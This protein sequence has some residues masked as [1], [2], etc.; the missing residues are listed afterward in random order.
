[1]VQVR[2]FGADPS[3]VGMDLYVPRSVRPHPAILLALA[4]CE[5]SGSDF[6][7]FTEFARLAD[8]YGFIVIYPSSAW[9]DG[10]WDVSSAAALRHDGGS[11]PVAFMSMITYVE[12]T[13]H[14]DPRRVYVTG[15]SS[16]AMM[17]A[18][19]LG[20]YP[21]VFKAGA[22]FMGVPFGCFAGPGPDV[23]DNACTSG[24][25]RMSTQR[26]GD[27]VRAADPGYHGPRPRVQIWHGTAD[28]TV[29]YADFGAEIRQWTN[30][31]GVS[32]TPVAT[33]HPR[34]GWT[35][36]EYGA[37]KNDI[38]IEAYSILGADHVLP[39]PGMEAYAIHF[40]G[41]DHG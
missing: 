18:V 21:G 8:Q 28:G 20:D 26:W 6:Y 36:A 31:F 17:T 16:G 40:F 14:A 4:E 7:Q 35:R 15:A 9:S 34:S 39:E 10:C 1:L 23:F 32:Q 29:T 27:L 2:A 25:V 5:E 19:M 12:R 37:G 24:E 3:K 38:D 22:I 33:D 11:D 30:V 13:D 41:L